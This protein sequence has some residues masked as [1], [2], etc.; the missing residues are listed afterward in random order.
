M[1][2]TRS[3]LDRLR[4]YERRHVQAFTEDY[5]AWQDAAPV[6]VQPRRA[7]NPV[8]M[9]NTMGPQEDVV[10]RRRRSHRHHVAAAAEPTNGGMTENLILLVLLAASIYG[11]YRLC[12]YLLMQAS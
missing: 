1:A 12:I 9:A 7:K 11:L 2:S 10:E 4:E 6:M 3:Q 8:D 5:A